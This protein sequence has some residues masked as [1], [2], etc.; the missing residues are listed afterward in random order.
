MG[1]IGRKCLILLPASAEDVGD[2]LWPHLIGRGAVTGGP[3]A[4]NFAASCFLGRLRRAGYVQQIFNDYH[5]STWFLTAK[6]RAV[7]S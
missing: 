5:T 3:T 4:T 6:G 2:E 7:K 1:P